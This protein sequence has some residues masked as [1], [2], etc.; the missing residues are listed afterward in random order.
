MV[1]PRFTSPF[2]CMRS[3]CAKSRL[4]CQPTNKGEP[5]SVAMSA[6][7][8]MSLIPT[9][10]PSMGDK[11]VPAF[12]RAVDASAAARAPAM[13]KVTKAPTASSCAAMTSRQRSRKARGESLPLV[14]APVWET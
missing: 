12:Q 5:C 4:P 6:V 1:L 10:M 11:V 2:R 8:M 9:G 14:N 7:S 13:F 3:R